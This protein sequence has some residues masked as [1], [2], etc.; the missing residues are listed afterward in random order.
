[1]KNRSKPSKK[2]IQEMMMWSGEEINFSESVNTFVL[3]F[4]FPQYK[5]LMRDGSATSPT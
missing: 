5:F 3:E 2:T 4:L 1:M